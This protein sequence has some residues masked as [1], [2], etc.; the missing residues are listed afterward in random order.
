MNKT[1]INKTIDGEVVME[2]AKELGKNL[3]YYSSKAVELVSKLFSNIGLPLDDTQ[4]KVLIAVIDL[5]L[6]YLFIA[7]LKN[8]NKFIKVIII[9][10]LLYLFIGFWI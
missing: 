8:L 4:I 10:L 1:I 3:F 2:S 9:F 5:F 6:I 7:V